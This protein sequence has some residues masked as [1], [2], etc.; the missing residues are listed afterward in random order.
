ME[1]YTRKVLRCLADPDL[2]KYME[3]RSAI[4]A[5][6]D[7]TIFREEEYVVFSV[8]E[9][10][11]NSTV[12]PDFLRIHL[13]RNLGEVVKADRTYLDLSRYVDMQKDQDP[14][15]IIGDI[16]DKANLYVM[17]VLGWYEDLLKEEAPSSDVHAMLETV[18]SIK[19]IYCV[20]QSIKTLQKGLTIL[21]SSYSERGKFLSGF[22]DCRDLVRRELSSLENL[23]DVNKGLGYLSY[24]DLLEHKDDT[25]PVEKVGT[26]AGIDELDKHFG[27]LYTQK[28]IT[29][30]APNKG[31]KTKFCMNLVY[32]AVVNHGQNVSLWAV[33]GSVQ[34][35]MAELQAIHF[36]RTYN[37]NASPE[38]C[39]TGITK[40]TILR[41]V[42]RVKSWKDECQ[43]LAYE[44]GS[45]PNYGRI[46]FID[47]PL[48]VESFI[49][50]LQVSVESNN[51]KIVVV[52]YLSLASSLNPRLSNHEIIR[53][54]YQKA[55]QYCKRA[56]ICL[57][58]P[59]QYTQ[60]TIRQLSRGGD[61]GSNDMRASV[62]GSAEILRSSDISFALWASTQ[63]LLDN[64][65]K[66]LSL[67]S[68][69][70]Q[71]FEPFEIMTDL[72]ACV[73]M[74]KRGG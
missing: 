5:N 33:E 66:F 7:K 3:C 62:G 57:I 27:G 55:S 24:T 32:D 74:S 4:F 70:G 44:L 6:L 45:N 43:S 64:R 22:E 20:D 46:D 54:V 69:V 2:N 73:F 49:D 16:S 26:F 37:K 10:N 11:K 40:D 29:V 35:M 34:E 56:N 68:R 61:G 71:A 15:I 18:E 50:D 1:K 8:I 25:K 60:E 36:D 58:S 23:F 63:D 12:S 17:G 52:D 42:W 28:L 21:T 51:S 67:P 53:E 19:Q 65:M 13:Q 59:A 39:K 48:F 30:A 47:K 72:G 9:K 38:N 14:S 31:G 41:D